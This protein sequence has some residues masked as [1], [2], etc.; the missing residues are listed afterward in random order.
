MKI[1]TK[2]KGMLL[3]LLDEKG[4][5]YIDVAKKLDIS[6]AQ[7]YR[8]NK[9]GISNNSKYYEKLKEIVPELKPKEPTL[10]KD[11]SLDMRVNGARKKKTEL[12]LTETDIKTP[13]EEKNR[14]SIFPK[15]TFRKKQSL[16]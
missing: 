15:I 7:L 14:D 10:K 16:K 5:S 13:S 12:H 6:T 3:R 1:S 8:W 11:G 4:I 2:G 9:N